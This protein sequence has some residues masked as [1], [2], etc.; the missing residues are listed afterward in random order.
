MCSAGNTVAERVYKYIRSVEDVL[1]G[2]RST[3]LNDERAREVLELAKAYLNDAKYYFSNGDYITS[4]SCIAYAEGLLDSL[5]ILGFLNFS[6]SKPQSFKVMVGGTFDIIHPGHIHYLREASKLGLVYAVVARDDTVRRIKG[7]E[8]INNEESR[9]EVINS[10]RYVYKALLGDKEDI[11]KSVE[12]IN[13]DI[14]LLG[15][16]QPVDEAALINYANRRGI[17]VNVIRLNTKYRAEEA[18]T[19]KI[20]NKILR[21]YCE[22]RR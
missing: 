21:L 2:V 19:T 3:S 9:L 6:W 16:D 15:P 7:R 1:E 8:P 18:S 14:I 13:P 17:N 4:L 5:R 11:F 22:D 12:S 20:I 10:I